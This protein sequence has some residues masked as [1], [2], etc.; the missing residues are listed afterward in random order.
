MSEKDLIEIQK[1]E[2]LAD[3]NPLPV[4]DLFLKSIEEGDT[5]LTDDRIFKLVQESPAWLGTKPIQKKIAEWQ[6]ILNNPLFDSAESTQAKKNLK[7]IYQ[8]L[9]YQGQGAPKQVDDTVIYL[10]YKN[11]KDDIAS[12]FENNGIRS[13]SRLSALLEAYPVYRDCFD[14]K[15]KRRSNTPG[16]IAI[17]I[18][19]K[20]QGWKERTIRAAISNNISSNK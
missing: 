17:Q 18:L 19:I 9:A 10:K 7:K 5:P 11:L 6:Y 20:R 2:L 14:L 12:F 16:E 1:K 3:C 13:T 15:G 4:D 8:A